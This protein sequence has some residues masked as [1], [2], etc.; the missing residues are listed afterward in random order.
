MTNP[1]NA[2]IQTFAQFNVLTL[3]LTIASLVILFLLR[4]KLH[5]IPFITI[6]VI[7]GAVINIKHIFLNY[8]D[9]CTY[10]GVDCRFYIIKTE[11]MIPPK[12]E[13]IIML[14]PAALVMTAVLIF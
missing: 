14:I 5:T 3:G 8:G 1:L 12:L 2:I 6:F 11:N 9:L 7:L 13:Q 4:N 10:T